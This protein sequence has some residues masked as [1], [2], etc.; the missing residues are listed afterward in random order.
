ML[1]QALDLYE[2]SIEFFVLC[3]LLYKK[4]ALHTIYSKFPSKTLLLLG[5]LL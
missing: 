4:K 1:E 2:W 5:N 3:G